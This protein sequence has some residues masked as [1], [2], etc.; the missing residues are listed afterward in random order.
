MA[1][2]PMLP[3]SQTRRLDYQVDLG[4]EATYLSP[5]FD[6]PS[7]HKYDGATYHHIAPCFGPDSDG[8]RRLI[9]TETPRSPST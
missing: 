6:S 7:A 5:V 8:D 3:W 2:R 9:A 4:F 1:F